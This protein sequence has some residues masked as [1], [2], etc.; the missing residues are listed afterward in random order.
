MNKQ[1]V[2]TGPLDECIVLDIP[3]G[4]GR[5]TMQHKIEALLTGNAKPQRR[6]RKPS[7]R[8]LIKQAERAGKTVTSIERDGVTLAFGETATSSDANPWDEVLK[9]ATN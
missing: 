2:A 8:S 7:L 3:A 6:A 4:A 9:N 1:I 5:T